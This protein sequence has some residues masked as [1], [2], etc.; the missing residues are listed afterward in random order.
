M[1][2]LI[3]YNCIAIWFGAFLVHWYSAYDTK[4]NISQNYMRNLFP[5][6]QEKS[7]Y[8]LDLILTPILGTGFA[9]I[10]IHPVDPFAALV[11]GMTWHVTFISLLKGKKK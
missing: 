10:T 2:F 1:E 5:N 11:S 3:K 9:W 4:F 7:Y 8:F 6:W